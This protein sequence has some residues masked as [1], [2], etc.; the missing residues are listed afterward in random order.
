MNKNIGKLDKSA[1]IV[2]G[3]AIIAYGIV[4][5]SLLGLIGIV[6]LATALIGWCPLYLPFNLSTCSK[7]ECSAK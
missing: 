2:I 7:E 1:R 3:L 6:P 4:E 5:S